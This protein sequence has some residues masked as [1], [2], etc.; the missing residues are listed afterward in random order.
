MELPD[1]EN[2]CK[3]KTCKCDK[4][5]NEST[6]V[7]SNVKLTSL[8]DAPLITHELTESTNEIFVKAV[9]VIKDS[10]GTGRIEILGRSI[11]MNICE[12]D[13][14]IHANFD[15]EIDGT[16]YTKVPFVVK[17]TESEAYLKLNKKSLK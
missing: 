16:E 3:C 9:D 13:N 4:A 10:C 17:L 5:I 15:I 14:T 11:L 6:K 7:V 12:S 2:N 1:T 8:F